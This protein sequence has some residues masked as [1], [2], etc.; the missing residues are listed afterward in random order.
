MKLQLSGQSLQGKVMEIAE[1]QQ[2]E[3]A[4]NLHNHYLQI[5][6][7]SNY[8]GRLVKLMSVVNIVKRLQMERKITIELANV[9]DF[10]NVELSDPDF[11]EG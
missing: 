4:D 3:L 5:K 10:F 8:A 7:R 9:F 1:I 11:F 6:R 2:E